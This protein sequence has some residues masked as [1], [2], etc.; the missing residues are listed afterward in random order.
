MLP[1]TLLAS[2]SV[3][4]LT[5]LRRSNNSPPVSISMTKKYVSPSAEPLINTVYSVTM[6]LCLQME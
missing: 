6:C 5:L 2:A 4:R 3:N 1:T